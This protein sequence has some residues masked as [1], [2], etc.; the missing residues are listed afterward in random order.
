MHHRSTRVARA[1][2]AGA[3]LS[4]FGLFMVGA[5]IWGAVEV[6]VEDAADQS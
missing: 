2:S 6:G 5:Y 1:L 4:A 3:V